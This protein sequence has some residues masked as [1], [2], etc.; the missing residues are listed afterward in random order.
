MIGK[1]ILHYKILEKLGEGG[2][3]VVYKAEDTKLKRIVALKFLPADLTRDEEAKKR[4]AHEAQAASALDHPNICN[5]HEIAE[6]DDGQVFICMAY[7][8]GETLQKKTSRRPLKIPEAIDIAIQVAD[9]LAKA[10]GQDTV[11]R[12]LKPANVMITKEGVLKILDFGLAKLAGATKLTKT[13]TTV[14]TAAYM[15]P[16]QAQGE[17]VD[18][19]ADI[20][21]LG[22]V[23][24]EM[25][26][27]KHPFKGDYEQAVMYSI[28]NEEPEPITGL[29]TGIPMELEKIVTKCLEKDPSERYQ[30]ADELLVDV[31]RIKKSLESGE[32]LSVTKAHIPITKEPE[33]K[34]IWRQPVSILT[35]IVA[36]MMLILGVQWI[37]KRDGEEPF[38]VSFEKSVA[39]MPFDNLTGDASFDVWRKGMS[40]LLSTALSSSRELYVL[41]NEVISDGL[42]GLGS[43]QTARIAPSL[44][45]QIARKAN[46]KIV[47]MGSIL[48]AGNKLR[49]QVKLQDVESDRILKS[50]TVDGNSEDDLFSM[51]EDISNRVKDYL[52]TKALKQDVDYELGQVFTSSAE[53]YRYYLQGMDAWYESDM[54]IAVQRWTQAASIDTN[55]M[56]AHFFL[57]YGY[58]NLAYDGNT[59]ARMREARK[60]A[61][62][63]YGRKNEVPYKYQVMLDFH[64]AHIEK[65]PRERI[66]WAKRLVQLDPQLWEAWFNIGYA[67][68]RL[69]QYNQAIKPLKKAMELGIQWGNAFKLFS[70]VIFLSGAHHELDEHDQELA[71]LKNSLDPL[72][73]YSRV[74]VI[75]SD[76]AL[77]NLCLGDTANAQTYF[78]QLQQDLEKIGSSK[79]EIATW[80]GWIYDRADQLDRAQEYYWQ[81]IAMDPK[82][83]RVLWWDRGALNLLADLLIEKDRDVDQGIELAQH[84]LR[85]DSEDFWSWHALG[86]GY[87]KQGNYKLAVE[88]LGKADDL[89]PKYEQPIPKHLKM[90]QAAL[91]QQN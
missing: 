17:E 48:K 7:Y 1:T 60:W 36:T 14:G 68:Y 31:R 38:V 37:L 44:A 16:Q 51:A 45:R 54:T 20:W 9:G 6:T 29:R 90:A 83:A 84:A 11:H 42:E 10:H 86:W 34:P 73:E 65:K 89:I 72:L 52:E 46:V 47:I 82:G 53:A 91:A 27:G 3:G 81:A 78:T 59:A 71:V 13:G 80:F 61:E 41:N 64:R 12:D 58:Q 19:R 33:K 87:Y 57:A 67:Y 88:A 74:Y 22:V 76:L 56:M 40:Q 63:A 2:M 5:I 35:A 32:S 50:E 66:K 24:Y 28:M 43:V 15:S 70:P 75:F 85:I 39:V 62:K 30:H 18:R 4:F 69:E 21:S 77:A 8:E 79:A 49:L 25:L 26:T 23:L 55:F